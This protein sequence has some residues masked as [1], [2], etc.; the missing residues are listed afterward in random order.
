[1]SNALLLETL[2]IMIFT[3]GN[4]DYEIGTYNITFITGVARVAFNFL[5]NDDNIFEVNEKFYLTINQSSLPE[6]IAVFELNKT[7]TVTIVDNDGEYVQ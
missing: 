1:M 2:D 3:G 7:A 4:T 5:I 6:N